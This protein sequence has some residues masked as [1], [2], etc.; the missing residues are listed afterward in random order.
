MSKQGLLN[1]LEG[2]LDILKRL[3]LFLPAFIGLIDP[4]KPK[5]KDD[6]AGPS[7]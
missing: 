4:P 6:N 1:I 7:V 3:V 2:M 5:I